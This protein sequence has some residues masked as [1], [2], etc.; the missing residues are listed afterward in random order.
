MVGEL[1]F[2]LKTVYVSFYECDDLTH[3]TIM[4]EKEF[5][6]L[7]IKIALSRN[8]LMCGT[9]YRAPQNDND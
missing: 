3:L 2:M 8:T 6:S 7:F 1:H 9:I 5:E 4:N